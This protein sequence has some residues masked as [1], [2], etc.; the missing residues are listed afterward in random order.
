VSDKALPGGQLPDGA[1]IHIAGPMEGGWRVITVW[2]AEEQF[3]RFR[4]VDEW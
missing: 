2:D 3:N 1:K 4:D